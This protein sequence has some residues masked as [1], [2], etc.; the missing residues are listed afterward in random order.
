MSSRRAASILLL[1]ALALSAS[2]TLA[3]NKKSKLA[4]GMEED[5]RALHALNRLTFGPRPGDVE[6]VRAMGVEKWIEQQLHPD[7]LDDAA[8][9][10]RLAP[11]RTLRMSARE[12]LEEFPPPP[13]IKAVAEGR[14]PMP[15]DARKRAIYEAQ[16]ERYRERQ[17]QQA[18]G[19]DTAAANMAA[20]RA[21]NKDEREFAALRAES[22][23]ALPPDQRYA[24]LLRTSGRDL[25]I[26]G[27][28]LPPPQRERLLEGFTP[29]QRETVVALANP[30]QVVN[31]ELASGK[32]LRAIY[33][34]RQL[35]EV[36]TDFWFNHFNVFLGKGADRYLVTSYER[37]VIRP[38][39]LGKFQDLLVATAKS[40]AM[41][42]YLDNWQSVGPNSEFARNGPKPRQQARNRGAHPRIG[43]GP[44]GRPRI[45]MAGP[46][47]PRPQQQRRNPQKP[48]A[49]RQRSGLN[50]NYARELMELHTLGVNGGYT[51]NDV[52]EVA[53][54]FTG[55]TLKEPRKG[56]DFDF[57]ESMHEPGAKNVL[58]RRVKEHGEDEGMQVLELLAHHPS[59]A[60]FIS[61]KLAERFVSDTPPDAL[62][63]RMTKSFLEHDG[64]IREVLRTM[65]RSPE[66]WAPEAYRAKV[67]T[68]LEFVV[69]AVRASGAEVS[70]AMPLAQTLNRMGMPLYGSQPPTGY[71]MK[72]ETWVNSAALLNR[73]NFGLAFAAG[74]LPGVAVDPLRLAA[75]AGQPLT[76]E[77]AVAVLEDALLAGDISRQ[78][79][80]TISKEMGDPKLNAQVVDDGRRAPNLALAAGL[81]FG[82]PEFQ[83]R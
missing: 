71:S 18:A 68:P 3:R 32:L 25:R 39:A 57:N 45:R 14:L 80:D 26:M 40:P 78:T 37:D 28:A 5:K 55:W 11:L 24:Q 79:H 38:H 51:Q 36:M 41:L 61:T 54:V 53:R 15:S 49:Q 74:R 63:E 46:P 13:V 21:T 29:E 62:V 6:R 35:A 33:S 58:G 23:A 44:F 7:K 20:D 81:I 10:A 59:T 66:F 56:G 30:Q 48:P 27:N 83:R 77:A 67:K 43:M 8:L 52:T 70:N 69:S 2:L 19:Q 31:G 65:F 47:Y 64:D 73:M 4:G 16:L 42:F 76:G 22:L 1:L 17:P 75:S 34:E 82:S 12:M 50:E 72:A 60:R 9:E